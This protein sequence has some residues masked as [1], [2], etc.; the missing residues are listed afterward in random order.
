MIKFTPYNIKLDVDGVMKSI[1]P[2]VKLALDNAEKY[3]IE[4]MGEAIDETSSAPHDWRSDMK[5]DLKH[6]REEVSPMVVKYFTGVEYTAGSGMW[7]RAMVIAYGMGIYG[8]N[9]NKIFAGPEGRTVWGKSLLEQH[10][11]LV[12]N[13][14][15]IPDSWYH[16]GG[17]FI[18]NAMS[19]MESIYEEAAQEVLGS[20][21]PSVFSSNISFSK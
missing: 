11:S 15:E 4:L 1:Q 5:A 6:V 13:Q 3:L 21:P 10:G 18:D 2:W 14:H 7:M 19:T 17:Y 16:G 8:L 20:I 9:G 12:K